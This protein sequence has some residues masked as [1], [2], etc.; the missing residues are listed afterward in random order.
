MCE[1]LQ[2]ARQLERGG[3]VYAFDT[4]LRDGAGDDSP[5]REIGNVVF[6]SILR[7]TRDFGGSINAVD[8]FSNVARHGCTSNLADCVSARTI[9]RFASSILYSLWPKPFAPRSSA[10]A[11]SR[12]FSGVAGFPVNNDSASFRRHGL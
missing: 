5:M 12:K 6:G 11:V 7:L 4:A 10:S 2:D 3:C 8:R 1:D 9:A